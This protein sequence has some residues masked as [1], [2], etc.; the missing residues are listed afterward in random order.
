MTCGLP[1]FQAEALRL[2]NAR[3]AAG[4]SCGGRS[5]PAAPAL[6][7]QAQLAQAAYGHSLDMATQNYFSHTSLDGRSLSDRVG[8]AGYVWSGVGENIAAGYGSVQAV[9]DGWMESSGHCANL[10]NRNYTE[11]ALACARDNG[12]V[13][14]IYWTQVL[15]RPR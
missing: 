7:W 14:R 10:M 6:R 2:V 12:S 13:Y 5:F 11:M 15:A 9:V 8:A 3:R 1:D 4:A